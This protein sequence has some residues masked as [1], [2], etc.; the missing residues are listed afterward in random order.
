[1]PGAGFAQWISLHSKCSY[2][3]RI[4]VDKLKFLHQWSV[5]WLLFPPLFLAQEREPSLSPREEG[6]FHLRG[7]KVSGNYL[8][9][10]PVNCVQLSQLE[11]SLHACREKLLSLLVCV[12]FI[13]SFI[14]LL[15]ICFQCLCILSVL[16]PWEIESK[17]SC[18]CLQFAQR[19]LARQAS[20]P[21][22]TM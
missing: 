2:S 10:V 13:H 18:P 3:L 12:S 22:T 20:K 15:S 9:K 5:W 6:S 11:R 1:M 4:D 21:I 14:P 17:G 8:R 16:S 7:G 19:Q